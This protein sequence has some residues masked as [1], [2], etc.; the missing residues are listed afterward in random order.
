MMKVSDW[1]GLAGLTLTVISVGVALRTLLRH[2]PTSTYLNARKRVRQHQAEL[3]ADAWTRTNPVW[4]RRGIPMLSRDGWILPAPV[5]LNLVQIRWSET[6]VTTDRSTT[7]AARVS[8]LLPRNPDAGGR[9]RYSEALVRI[10]HMDH[11]FN[12]TVYRP[13]SVT[14]S[15]GSFAL[16][17]REGRY[18]DYLDTSEILAYEGGDGWQ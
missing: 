1:I 14:A 2:R 5:N 4:K 15:P 6:P 11:L 16:D 12:G 9:L 7:N 3:S 17:F 8:R 13:V 10:D 18:F